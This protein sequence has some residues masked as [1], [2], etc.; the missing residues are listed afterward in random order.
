MSGWKSTT[1]GDV[2]QIKG[3][4]RLPPGFFVQA[5]RTPYPYIRVTDMRDGGVD[6]SDIKYVPVQAART[7]QAYT[8]RSQDLFISVA[9]TLGLVGRIP[10]ALDGANLTENADRLT[11][12]KCDVDYLAHYLRSPLI[13][14][15]I[16]SIR[17][18]G[19]QP[20]LALSRIKTFELQLPIDL[21]EQVRV[22]AALNNADDLIDSLERLIA[23][24][25]DI[26]QGMMQE[27]LTGRTRLPGFTGKWSRCTAADIGTFKG[28]SGFPTRLQGSTTGKFPYFK[29]SDMNLEGNERSM[30]FAN[31]WIDEETRALLGATALPPGAVVFAKVGAA[32]FLERKRLLVA[33]SCIDNNMVAFVPTSGVTDFLFVYYLFLSFKMSSLVAVGALP[34]LNGSQLRSIPIFLPNNVEE[35]SEIAQVLN[36]ADAEIA[37]LERRLETVRA[38]KMGMMQELLTG[39]TRLV[40]EE[41]A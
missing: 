14:N 2:A 27:L 36:D 11:D 10:D 22:S 35:Q 32:V 41:A 12:I 7:I 3:G 5:E 20:K 21:A 40:S 38:I 24:K 39:R 8:I 26:K 33:S 4:K 13:Q 1:V 15:E 9:G 25:R 23:K 34:S 37:A 28:G 19:A 18:V 30:I 6:Q 16:E 29:V 17:T 31:N